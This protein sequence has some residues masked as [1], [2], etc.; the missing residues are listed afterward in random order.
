MIIFE[1]ILTTFEESNIFFEAAGAVMEIGK[2][3]NIT[4]FNQVKIVQ[5]RDTHCRCWDDFNEFEYQ[6]Q[7]D[8]VTMHLIVPI[9]KNFY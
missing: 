5:S 2:S 3:L 8:V 6:N 4:I 9:N 7:K 1:S